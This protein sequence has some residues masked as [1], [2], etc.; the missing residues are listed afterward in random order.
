MLFQGKIKLFQ[1]RITKLHS[2]K[3]N[4][5]TIEPVAVIEWGFVIGKFAGIVLEP[6]VAT[7]TPEVAFGVKLDHLVR[8]VA[9]ITASL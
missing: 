4:D 1:G 2:I 9:M 5:R 6:V 3:T 7:V 8:R